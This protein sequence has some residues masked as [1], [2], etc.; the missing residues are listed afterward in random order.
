MNN[1][2]NWYKFCLNKKNVICEVIEETE[3][4]QFISRYFK[5]LFKLKLN[6]SVSYVTVYKYIVFY[7]F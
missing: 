4:K 6:C 5:I 3:I 2:F 7:R 1:F